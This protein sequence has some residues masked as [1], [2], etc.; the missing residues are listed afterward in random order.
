[1]SV[2]T[3]APTVDAGAEGERLRELHDYGLLDYPASHEL[4]A[5]LRVAAAVAGVPTATLN[6]LDA[7]HQCQ[8]TTV[9]FE[10]S[11][12]PR[13][14]SMC[15][16]T[17][18]AGHAIHIPDARV[19]PRFADNLWVTG[20]HASVR[21]YASVPLVTPA[22]HVL[23]TLCVF[24]DVVR[25]LD[26][27]ARARLADC[28]AVVMALFEQQ[29][30][31]RH[32]REQADEARRQQ[33]VA[34]SSEARFRSAFDQ[35]PNP[36]AVLTTDRRF[37]DV[38]PAFCGWLGWSRN[39]LVGRAVSGLGHR[40]ERA[41]T[42]DAE[43]NLLLG[44][45]SSARLDRRFRHHRG[46][47]LWGRLSMGV[48]P[49]PDG[50]PQLIWQ[51]EDITEQRAAEKRL[52]RLALHD[53]LTGLANRTLLLEKVQH[54]LAVGARDGSSHAVLF[55]DLDGFKQ[56]NDTYGH[57][58]GDELL[59]AVAERLARAVRPSDTVARLGG[60]EF[61]LLCEGVGPAE[62][63]RIVRRLAAAVE[64]D[65]VTTAGPV[66]VG[67]SIGVSHPVRG[68]G[69]TAAAAAI[70]EADARMYESKSSRR[71]TGVPGPRLG[72]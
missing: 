50:S 43:R 51:V 27:G 24:D 68:S 13:D 17:L 71:G 6:L 61:V 34:R 35:A 2:A 52:T 9:G 41:A 32:E 58:V 22:G 15:E 49:G 46:E 48:V 44:R 36:I 11:R 1:M 62:V 66:R 60:D 19:D 23:G 8:L 57:A 12:T 29:R 30:M 64:T 16:V 26:D 14:E 63:E 20:V 55:C 28:A 47:Y 25:T 70:A 65:V 5:I 72:R 54:A 67:A 40:D 39:D 7:T 21:F 33:L 53:H 59:V 31:A 38:N 45:V 42:A 37:A 3:P 56:V 69:P 4:E 10:G 18:Q